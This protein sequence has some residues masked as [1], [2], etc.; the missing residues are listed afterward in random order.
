MV[1]TFGAFLTALALFAS[2]PLA[3]VKLARFA[4]IEW[5]GGDFVGARGV[6]LQRSFYDCGPAALA[7]LLA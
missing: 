1:V 7:N 3:T 6:V 4:V 2:R 5:N